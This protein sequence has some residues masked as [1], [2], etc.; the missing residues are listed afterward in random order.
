[1]HQTFRYDEGRT[2][3]DVER[4]K[5]DRSIKAKLTTEQRLYIE[6]NRAA[7]GLDNF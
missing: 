7:L 1:M 5:I 6:V 3:A 4:M 2:E